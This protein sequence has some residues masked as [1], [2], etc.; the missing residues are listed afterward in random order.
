LTKRK[1]RINRGPKSKPWN[2]TQIGS[3]WG[4]GTNYVPKLS[5]IVISISKREGLKEN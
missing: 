1:R 3:Q 2:K 4:K 5:S